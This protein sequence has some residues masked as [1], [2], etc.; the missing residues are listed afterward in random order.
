MPWILTLVAII[1][2]DNFEQIFIL[3]SPGEMHFKYIYWGSA[4]GYC[5][6]VVIGLYPQFAHIY[7]NIY[8]VVTTQ[9]NGYWSNLDWAPSGY[10]WIMV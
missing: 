8:T 6:N 9:A 1:V 10:G 3:F 5:H 4:S 7:G 2:S